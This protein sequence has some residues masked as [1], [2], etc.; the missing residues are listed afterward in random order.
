VSNREECTI[1]VFEPEPDSDT[2]GIVLPFL[3]FSRSHCSG[4]FH[5]FVG[6]TATINVVSEN[7]EITREQALQ[8]AARY[9]TRQCHITRVELPPTEPELKRIIQYENRRKNKFYA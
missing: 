4:A 5:S 8:I 2:Y 3:D 7:G 1:Y 9:V 6:K